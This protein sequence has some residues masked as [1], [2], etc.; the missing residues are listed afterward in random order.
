M[1]PPSAEETLP[2]QDADIDPEVNLETAE[3]YANIE[4]ADQGVYSNSEGNPS[5]EEAYANQEEEQSPRKDDGDGAVE[6]AE[7]NL[8]ATSETPLEQA[9][10][11]PISWKEA[12]KASTPAKEDPEMPSF[13]DAAMIDQI[14][15][16]AKQSSANLVVLV[17]HLRTQLAAISS[18]SVQYM[19][20]HKT[21]IE[22][23]AEHM[24]DGIAATQKLIL[25]AQT[26]NAELRKISTVQSDIKETKRLLSQLEKIVEKMVKS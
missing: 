15:V 19:T 7:D 8:A 24:H 12:A 17:H 2:L 5:G 10:M 26:L 1:D 23:V 11:T 25:K 9:P 3:E 14:E 21:T 20:L 22:G 6:D 18:L 16:N 4:N 13:V